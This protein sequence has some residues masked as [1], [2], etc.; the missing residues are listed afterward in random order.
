LEF[1]EIA[2]EKLSKKVYT[3]IKE[4]ITRELIL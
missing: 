3:K 4:K 2:L 1:S